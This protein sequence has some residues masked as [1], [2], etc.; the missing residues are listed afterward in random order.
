MSNKTLPR[1][2][3]N[4]NPGNIRLGNSIW[5]GE[6]RPSRDP[7]FCQFRDMKHGYRALIRLLQNYRRKNKCQTIAD[8]ISR[9][10]PSS[11]NNT[12]AYILDVCRYLQVPTNFVPDI[13]DRDTMCGLAAAISRHEN[14][15]DAEMNDI[16]EAWNLL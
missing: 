7:D 5:V 13:E 8:M 6:I 1:G 12:H 14:G 10:A 2:L 15:V 16:Q 11:E 4:N 3:R 9:W